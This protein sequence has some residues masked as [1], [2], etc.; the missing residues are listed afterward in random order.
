MC[1]TAPMATLTQLSWADV[2]SRLASARNYWLVTIRA[3]GA[4][5]AVPV[6]GAVVGDALCCYTSQG[7][8]KAK[9]LARDARVTVHLESAEEVVIVDGTFEN[10]GAPSGHPDIVKALDDKYPDPDDAAY[11]PSHDPSFDVL[12]R[13]HPVSARMW[14]LAAFEDSQRRWRA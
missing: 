3:T 1:Q 9:N 4:P 7:T 5:H 11:L 8:T 13:L 2:A 10:L 14:E 6:W 12:Y